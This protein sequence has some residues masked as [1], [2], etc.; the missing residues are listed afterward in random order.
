MVSENRYLQVIQAIVVS[1][2]FIYLWIV[3]GKEEIHRQDGWLF[4]L[5][6]FGLMTQCNPF[7]GKHFRCFMPVFCHYLERF[8]KDKKFTVD[9]FI[10]AF[11]K[12][13]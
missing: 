6:G 5:A 12:K 11:R 8:D 9:Y 4:I 1:V 3:G 10:E 13:E 2:I 7:F